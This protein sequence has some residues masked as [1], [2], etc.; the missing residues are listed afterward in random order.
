MTSRS[1]DSD[2]SQ[3]VTLD[4]QLTAGTIRIHPTTGPA[5]LVVSTHD[6]DGPSADAVKQSRIDQNGDTITVRVPTIGGGTVIQ[7]GRG[8]IQI[9]HGGGIFVSG[10]NYGG[11]N[12]VVVNGRVIS[13]NTNMIIG[14][15][16]ILIEAWLPDGSSLDADTTSADV[17]AS[18]QLHRA[19]VQTVSGDIRLNRVQFPRLHSTS[20]DIAIDALAGPG[21]VKTVSG[22]IRVHA[23][24]EVALIAKSVSG[25][26]TVSGARVDLDAR[27]VSGRVRNGSR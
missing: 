18:A 13:G 7:S 24:A 2:N 3:P 19:E 27:S 6:Q 5:H 23:A 12:Q 4:V 11:M 1:H 21:R 25:D 8:N 9:N 20:G 15:S 22:D 16:P 10:D 26:V 14:G 17:E